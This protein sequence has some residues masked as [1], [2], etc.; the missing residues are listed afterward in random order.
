MPQQSNWDE[1]FD[2]LIVAIDDVDFRAKNIEPVL[3]GAYQREHIKQMERAFDSN[4]ATT[5]FG[6]WRPT[7]RGGTILRKSRRLF[8][9]YTDRNGDYIFRV[10]G[11]AV[12]AGSKNPY[13]AVHQNGALSRGIHPRKLDKSEEDLNTLD[14]LVMK[15]IDT[16]E[17]GQ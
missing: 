12:L 14:D 16:G 13:A 6:T 3:R 10:E 15:Y 11:S 9:S 8:N 1:G 5:R 2:D 4:G 7:Q 17:G